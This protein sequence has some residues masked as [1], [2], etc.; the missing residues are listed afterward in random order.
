[1]FLKLLRGYYLFL[2]YKYEIM[3]FRIEEVMHEKGFN[4]VKLAQALGVTKSTIS[5]NLKKPSLDTLI[6]IAEVLDVKVS[7]LLIEDD[8]NTLEPIY[9]K[10]D[11]KD[12]VIGYLKKLS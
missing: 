12:V 6:R 3:E 2:F 4:N 1:M 5:N 8:R 10:E 11:G 9:K 7:D